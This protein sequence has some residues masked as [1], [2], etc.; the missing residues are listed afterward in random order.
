MNR[1]ALEAMIRSGA[2]DSLNVERWVL[3]TSLDDALKAAEQSAS[4]R[5][6]GMADL[7]GEV[8]PSSGDNGEDVYKEFRGA[9][10]WTD[11]ERLGGERDTLGLYIT[12]HPID[13]YSEEVRRFAPN[14][15]ASLSP[16]GPGRQGSGQT[17]SLIHISEPTRPY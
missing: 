13:E 15:I 16:D 7:F 10:A 6:S 14:R 1:R 2:L 17:L 5:D 4:N 3:M 12:G 11:K 9:R 8:V